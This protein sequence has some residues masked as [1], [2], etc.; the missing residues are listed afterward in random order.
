MPQYLLTAGYTGICCTQ[1]R[2]VAA[3]SIAKRVS[4]ELDVD[5][6]EEVGYSIRFED[7][8][9]PRTILKYLTDGMLLREAIH[10]PDLER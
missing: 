5:L 7:K 10:D 1:P 2:R 8:T 3:M 4:E 9:S 6:G